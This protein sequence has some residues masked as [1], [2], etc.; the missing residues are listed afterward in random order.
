MGGGLG[1]QHFGI[2]AQNALKARATS[3]WCLDNGVLFNAADRAPAR[4]CGQNEIL[5]SGFAR[6]DA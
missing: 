6:Y 5:S 1:A 2:D 4:L 3:I